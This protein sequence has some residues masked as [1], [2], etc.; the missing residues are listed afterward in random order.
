[1]ARAA[2]TSVAS[3][4]NQ[5][6]DSASSTAGDTMPALRVAMAEMEHR[7][8]P[9][10]SNL[11]L[12]LPQTGPDNV[13]IMVASDSIPP[14]LKSDAWSNTSFIGPSTA[15]IEELDLVP[16]STSSFTKSSRIQP[17][18]G[19]TLTPPYGPCDL[20]E[21][22]P[23]SNPVSNPTPVSSQSHALSL[24][25]SEQVSLFDSLFSLARPGEEYYQSAS[26]ARPSHISN[27]IVIAASSEISGTGWD[28]T[29]RDTGDLQDTEG[30]SDIM[31]KT[32]TLD[33]NVQS[34]TLPFILECRKSFIL[35]ESCQPQIFLLDAL[36][37][38]RMIF[39]PLRVAAAGREYVL[40]Q[41]ARS[42]V[43]RRNLT[44]VSK[45][46][47]AVA[48]STAFE[49][50]NVPG[51]AAFRSHMSQGYM[52]VKSTKH[53]SRSEELLRALD[54]IN[55]SYEVRLSTLAPIHVLKCHDS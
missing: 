44:L 18:I 45:F 14:I 49:T 9:E 46:A 43:A 50:D 20:P 39:Q 11:L 36:W 6:D 47:R 42:D 31:V 33:R 4:L 8:R 23:V 41:Y 21:P 51:L 10:T 26:N 7:I 48:L 35:L 22:N 28:S 54:A 32:L 2:T 24:M 38:S 15:T 27:Q 1:M 19:Q 37:I 25:T 3:P 16:A 52:I 55:S 5:A 34:N 12:R 17:V 40:R 30:I 53:S 13:G 29:D